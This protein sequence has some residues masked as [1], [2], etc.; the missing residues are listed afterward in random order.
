[1][2]IDVD[3]AHVLIV[4]TRDRDAHDRDAHDPNDVMPQKNTGDLDL[5]AIDVC[6]R[7]FPG[8]FQSRNESSPPS[9]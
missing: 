8:R 1:L 3:S 9:Q 6:L 7:L 4:R 5:E 2:G